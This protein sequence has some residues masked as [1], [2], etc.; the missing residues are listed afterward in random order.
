MYL[1]IQKRSR[2]PYF[3]QTGYVSGT[4]VQ[5]RQLL[6]Y[7]S[8]SLQEKFRCSFRKRILFIL[9][10]LFVSNNHEFLNPF[11]GFDL[12]SVEISHRILSHR[13][14]GMEL[15]RVAAIVS[16]GAENGA[17]SPAEMNFTET[18]TIYAR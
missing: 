8:R 5:K 1:H 17:E 6:H 3:S 13:M 10:E 12:T 11:A 4:T 9:T 14:H 18:P 15:A 16:D 2:P 7:L